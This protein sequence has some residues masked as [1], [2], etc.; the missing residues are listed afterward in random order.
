MECGEILLHALGARF[1]VDQSFE[2]GEHVPAVFH[3]A[4]ED[5]AQRG[6]ALGLAM[7]FEQH[8]GRNFD[9]AAKLFGGVSA[10]EQAVEEGRF[11][12]RVVEVVLGFLRPGWPR[13]AIVVLVSVCISV[14]RQK[15]QF[16]GSF[17]GV[18]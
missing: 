6:F 11:P 7:P 8:R 3:H 16:T 9:V 12:L 13:L 2:D 5:I 10:Q 18:K 4:G 1:G 17:P 14:T 15:R